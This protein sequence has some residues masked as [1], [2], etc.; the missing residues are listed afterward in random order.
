MPTLLSDVRCWVN[1]GKHLL[2]ASISPF[3]PLQTFALVQATALGKVLFGAF[4]RCADPVHDKFGLR[5]GFGCPRASYLNIRHA[6]HTCLSNLIVRNLV[7]FMYFE[8]AVPAAKCD[9]LANTYL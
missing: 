8:E 4:G 2:A 7:G 9:T 6:V 3:D 1:S 5:C